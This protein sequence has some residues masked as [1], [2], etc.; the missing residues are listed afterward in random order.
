MSIISLN[1]KAAVSIFL[2]IISFFACSAETEQGPRSQTVPQ[3]KTNGNADGAVDPTTLEGGANLSEAATGRDAST[4]KPGSDAKI[5][6]CAREPVIVFVIDGSGSMCADFGGATRWQSLR[7][8]LLDPQSGLITLLDDKGLFGMLL[9]DGTV[10]PMLAMTATG[11]TPNP[12]CAARS[13]MER[14][15][16]DCPQVIA[17]SPALNN[18]PKIDAAFPQTELGGSTPTDKAMNRAV[19]ELLASRES[20]LDLEIHPQYIILATDGQPN[21]ICV[22]GVGGDGVAQQQGVIAAVDRAAQA[23]ISTFVISLAGGDAALEAH[24]DEVAR[25]G[26]PQNPGARTYSPTTPQDLVATLQE[27]LRAAFGCDIV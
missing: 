13:A 5:D 18:A 11:G 23:G 15:E 7:S 2:I 21:D 17:V 19:D 12:T 8:T 14:M 22:G 20:G 1:E 3:N 26:N 25:H 4:V 10:D 16:G 27:L 24:L 9:Y 6:P